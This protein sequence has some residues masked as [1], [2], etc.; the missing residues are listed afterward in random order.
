MAFGTSIAVGLFLLL[1]FEASAVVSDCLGVC[2]NGE[3][4]F[5]DKG[6]VGDA[7]LPQP[8]KEPSLDPP[9]DLGCD[10]WIVELE[11][12]ESLLNVLDIPLGD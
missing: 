6:V 12:V 7:P 1:D 9:G 3:K 4:E 5:S 8:K 2:G 11:S 10:L